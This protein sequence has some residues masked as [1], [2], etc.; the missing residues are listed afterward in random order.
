MD[1]CIIFIVA[2]VRISFYSFSELQACGAPHAPEFTALCQLAHI[3]CTG[4]ASSK[5]AAKQS[6]AQAMLAF[7]EDVSQNEDQMQLATVEAELPETT[8]RKYRELK[9][10]DIKPI[11]IRIRDR[12][13]FFH[14]LPEGDRKEAYK[15]LRS[16]SVGIGTNKDKIDLVCKALKLNYEIKDIPGHIGKNKI[17]TL[18]GDY[19][20]VITDKEPD[21]Y[22]RLVKYFIRMLC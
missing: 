10:S 21:L 4:R 5:K 3:K 15:I 13:N 18:L 6:A 8:F 22:D 17:F 19:D 2:F 11:S 16:D 7:V 12:H 20:C 1:E 9:H 14:R